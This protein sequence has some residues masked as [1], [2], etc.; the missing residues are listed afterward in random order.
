MLRFFGDA[1]ALLF[2]FMMARSVIS[3]VWKLLQGRVPNPAYQ[4]GQQGEQQTGSRDIR[5]S[6][7]LRKDPN[8]GTFVATSSVYTK[9]VNGD[10]VYFC[11]KECRDSYKQGR[12]SDQW[13]KSSAARS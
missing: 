11:S 9:L 8:C 4:P 12:T 7:E 5:T 10:T 3:T 6:G 2:F 1:I 13:E